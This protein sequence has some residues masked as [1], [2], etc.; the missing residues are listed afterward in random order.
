[1]TEP[2]KYELVGEL[3]L[4]WL[5]AQGMRPWHR[6]LDVGCGQ[7]RGG[8]HLIRYLNIGNYVGLEKD[9]GMIARALPV[10]AEL[11]YREPLL[12]ETDAFTPPAFAHG[13]YD[14]GLAF[15]VFTHLSPR[16]IKLCLQR[17]LPIVGRLYATFNRGT[18]VELGQ[19]HPV[20]QSEWR[21][22]RYPFGYLARLA[23]T[24]GGT[25][26]DLGGFGHPCGQQMGVF[27]RDH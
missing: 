9:A 18:T 26:E 22:C 13:H 3:Q 20:R 6:L 12:Y 10:L 2:T 17:I 16:L 19:R 24:A 8:R 23:E 27:Y 7:L 14:Y 21:R 25:A 4:A 15:S 5:K 1:M 11:A